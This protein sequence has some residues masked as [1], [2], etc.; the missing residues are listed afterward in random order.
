[1]ALYLQQLQNSISQQKEL[2]RLLTEKQSHLAYKAEKLKQGSANL[3]N[4]NTDNDLL[5]ITNYELESLDAQISYIKI[6]N[7]I[8]SLK[9]VI[10]EKES[11]F[12]KYA[13]E[14][15]KDWAEV[16]KHFSELFLKAKSSNNATVKEFLARLN[17]EMIERE[18]QTKVFIYKRLKALLK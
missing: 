10:D 13:A 4:E 18:P 5:K 3:S 17:Y 9:K 15:E 12:K 6:G 14:F 8:S 2:L 7:E 1:M 16:E 11:Y